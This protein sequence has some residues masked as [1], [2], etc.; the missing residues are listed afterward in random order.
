MPSNEYSYF[1]NLSAGHAQHRNALRA[2]ENRII[3]I[4]ARD[5]ASGGTEVLNTYTTI[6]IFPSILS[7][8]ERQDAFPS[9]PSASSTVVRRVAHTGVVAHYL[10]RSSTSRQNASQ[11]QRGAHVASAK[12][13][14]ERPPASWE[15]PR[16]NSKSYL[17]GSVNDER[18]PGCVPT[19]RPKTRTARCLVP[20]CSACL[21]IRTVPRNSS[22]IDA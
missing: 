14:D 12:I 7:V 18:L 1:S 17:D 4:L 13:G 3:V 5:T 8:L 9:P 15:L 21:P 22:R 16:T 11:R 6:T 20:G 2:W 19:T 10:A